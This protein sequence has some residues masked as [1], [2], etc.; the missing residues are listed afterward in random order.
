M[1]SWQGAFRES[2]TWKLLMHAQ[3]PSI[4]FAPLAEAA[5]AAAVLLVHM[6]PV[7]AISEVIRV[8]LGSTSDLK[9]L[10]LIEAFRLQFLGTPQW[11]GCQQHTVPDIFICKSSS[12][13]SSEILPI[14]GWECHLAVDSHFLEEPPQI[15]AG[16]YREWRGIS[17]RQTTRLCCNWMNPSNAKRKRQKSNWKK[18]FL[19]ISWV[20]RKRERRKLKVDLESLFEVSTKQILVH[21]DFFS[22]AIR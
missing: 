1:K 19:L 4:D 2:W 14:L 8:D 15:L 18:C 3:S 7:A 21:S 17:A 20:A 12:V 22:N 6:A 9:R 11:E 13:A 16:V 10:Q 5:A